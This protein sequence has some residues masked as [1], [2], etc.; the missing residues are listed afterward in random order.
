MN[1]QELKRRTEQFALRVMKLIFRRPLP[2]RLAGTQ[3]SQARKASPI[4]FPNFSTPLPPIAAEGVEKRVGGGPPVRLSL[5]KLLTGEINS[6]GSLRK[7]QN[8][9]CREA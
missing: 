9:Q 7:Y 8:L 4:K 6:A 2:A 5:R 3:V 1:E